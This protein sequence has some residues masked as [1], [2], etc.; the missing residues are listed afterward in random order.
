MMLASASRADGAE[1]IPGLIMLAAILVDGALNAIVLIAWMLPRLRKR[2]PGGG[3]KAFAGVVLVPDAIA[4]YA[5]WW[6]SHGL[7]EGDN[8]VNV[9]L[10][11]LVAAALKLVAIAWPQ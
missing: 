4:V 8:T 9:L 7:Q 1:L 11:I 2:R 10:A 6:A 3:F 5:V